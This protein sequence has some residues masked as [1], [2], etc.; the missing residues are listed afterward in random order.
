MQ[1]IYRIT[2][3]PSTNPAPWA[4]DDKRELNR[5]CL[6]SFVEAF[7]DVK[8]EIHF[9]ADHCDHLLSKMIEDYVSVDYEI[10]YTELGI[11]GTMLRAYELACKADDYV[12]L[13]ECDHLWV[14]GSGKTMLAAIKQ[15]GLISG[16]DHPDF[17]SRFDIHPRETEIVLVD[18]YHFRKS[19]RNV[20]SWGC[21]SDL[22][23]NNLDILKLH[24]YLDDQV[25]PDLRKAGHQLYTAIPALSTHLVDSY[26]APGVDWEKIWIKNLFTA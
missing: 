11:N 6:K 13:A 18:G 24:G 26:M 25:W 2:D 15:L 19:A 17:Y 23:K 12:L 20:M 4:Q 16:Y 10:E 21:H 9:I 5:V 8:H 14:P 1:V 22:I 7:K 3:I